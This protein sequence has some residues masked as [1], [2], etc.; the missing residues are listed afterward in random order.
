MKIKDEGLMKSLLIIITAFL[1]LTTISGCK[2]LDKLAELEEIERLLAEMQNNLIDDSL[3]L[4][5]IKTLAE[6]PFSTKY[7]TICFDSLQKNT[8]QT[9]IKKVRLEGHDYWIIVG[10]GKQMG[11]TG[12]THSESCWCTRFNSAR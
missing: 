11:G 6:T 9:A 7:D 12:I 2:E 8:M 3:R 5:S 4:D 10:M 1:V